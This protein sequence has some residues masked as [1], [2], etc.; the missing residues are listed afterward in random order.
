MRAPELPTEC[1]DMIFACINDILSFGRLASTCRDLRDIGTPI[2]LERLR[3]R[4]RKGEWLMNTPPSI[5]HL[6]NGRIDGPRFFSQKGFNS[7]G[8]KYTLH[9]QATYR[10]GRLHG[11]SNDVYEYVAKDTKTLRVNGVYV[12][13]R[14]EQGNVLARSQ[15]GIVLSDHTESKHVRDTIIYRPEAK[16]KHFQRTLEWQHCHGI[17]EAPDLYYSLVW[18]GNRTWAVTQPNGSV[19]L[20][21]VS[22]DDKMFN[23]WSEMVM[24]LIRTMHQ[25]RRTATLR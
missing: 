13:G 3:I 11:T 23:T 7:A 22:S 4:L 8:G 2:R 12:D 19:T 6:P 25:A 17:V 9:H 14:I 20:M 5:F 1:W 24:S 10:N 16:R 21:G 18:S 15:Q